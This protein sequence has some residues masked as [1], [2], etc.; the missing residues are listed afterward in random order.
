VTDL[1]QLEHDLRRKD[2]RGGSSLKEKL[3]KKDKGK[4]AK[5]AVSTRDRFCLKALFSKFNV[6]KN[7]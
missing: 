7:K 3:G 2:K 4:K 6:G 1:E 5:T